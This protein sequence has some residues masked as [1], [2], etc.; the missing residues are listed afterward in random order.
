M[1]IYYYG[2]FLWLKIIKNCQK[3][4]YRRMDDMFLLEILWGC[5]KSQQ[6][7]LLLLV[8]KMI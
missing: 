4:I 3:K 1:G 5:P 8:L 6:K 2:V 7:T